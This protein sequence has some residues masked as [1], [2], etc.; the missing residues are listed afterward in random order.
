M[1]VI[2]F[3]ESVSGI[4]IN[5]GEENLGTVSLSKAGNGLHNL[6]D[7]N[8][9]EPVPLSGSSNSVS[10]DEN[11]SGESSLVEVLVMLERVDH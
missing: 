3:E 10:V 11:M 7:F 5:Q 6:F 2:F 8:L 9:H 4:L 1:S